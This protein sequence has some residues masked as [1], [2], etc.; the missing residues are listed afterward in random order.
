VP[1]ATTLA[2]KANCLRNLPDDAAD[3][4]LGNKKRLAEAIKL[5]QEA[6]QIFAGFQDQARAEM[7]S[8]VI[9]ELED[10]IENGPDQRGTN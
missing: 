2:N 3:P 8:E 7:L 1:Y 6:R 5:Y 4:S 9:A 10:E